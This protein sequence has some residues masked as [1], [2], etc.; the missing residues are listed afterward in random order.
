MCCLLLCQAVSRGSETAG[1]LSCST[2]T[3]FC[4]PGNFS[5][6]LNLLFSLHCSASSLCSSGQRALMHS[7]FPSV[8]PSERVCLLYCAIQRSAAQSSALPAL[9]SPNSSALTDVLLS[10]DATSGHSLSTNKST[11]LIP[12]LSLFLSLTHSAPPHCWADSQCSSCSQTRAPP[13]HSLSLISP[14]L[15]ALTI[16]VQQ[17]HFCCQNNEGAIDEIR[18]MKWN[19]GT[20]KRWAKSC[21]WQAL[22]YAKC[23]HCQC[24]FHT[25]SFDCTHASRAF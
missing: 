4:W 14:S 25:A 18:N 13:L 15:F 3:L 8:P 20:E 2:S 11:A 1:S 12:Q 17:F 5:P 19:N 23:S 24:S 7:L 22:M 6:F 9:C 21:L 10:E 16:H